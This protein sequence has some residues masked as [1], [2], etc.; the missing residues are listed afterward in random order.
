[1]GDGTP[2]G[3]RVIAT[4][5]LQGVCVNLDCGY[6]ITTAGICKSGSLLCGNDP[7]NQAL[8]QEGFNLCR[9]S[10]ATAKDGTRVVGDAQG[11]LLEWHVIT[12]RDGSQA[13]DPDYYKSF[14]DSA[15]EPGL[16]NPHPGY[17][18]TSFYLKIGRSEAQL[19]TNTFPAVRGGSGTPEVPAT[20]DTGGASTHSPDGGSSYGGGAT[21]GLASGG[22]EGGAQQAVPLGTPTDVARIS[23]VGDRR[24]LMLSVFGLLEV[25]LLCNLTAMALS[26]RT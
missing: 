22:G 26:R 23:A 20:G 9:L 13:P 24:P 19:L 12:R 14:G 21:S 16:S 3:T 5:D 1:V 8:R 25:I 10:H 6:S 15:C 2:Q 7:V 17:T 4:N 18:G 11:I